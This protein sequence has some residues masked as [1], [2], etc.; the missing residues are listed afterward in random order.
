[1]S[2]SETNDEK[3]KHSFYTAFFWLLS[4]K[5]VQYN[6]WAGANKFEELNGPTDQTQCC[7]KKQNKNL[8]TLNVIFS[9]EEKEIQASRPTT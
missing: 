2:N 3:W 9:R 8:S 1:M 5:N 7:N 4:H 6:F